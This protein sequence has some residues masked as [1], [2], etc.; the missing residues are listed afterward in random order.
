MRTKLLKW[1]SFSHL[2][3]GNLNFVRPDST[4]HQ[5]ELLHY[6]YLL[7]NMIMQYMY[8]SLTIMNIRK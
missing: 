2:F 4:N 8:N 1:S 7:G 6:K 5:V 3:G